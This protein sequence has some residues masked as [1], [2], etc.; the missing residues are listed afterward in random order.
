[1][2]LIQICCLTICS[3][4]TVFLSRCQAQPNAASATESAIRKAAREFNEAF[5]RGDAD[6]VA[7]HFTPN[8]V[9]V[10]DRGQRFEGRDAIRTEYEKLFDNVSGLR[11]VVEIDSI[12]ILNDTTA[13]EEG[14]VALMP[15]PAGANRVMSAYS[16]VHLLQD[17]KWLMAEVRD[18]R[19]VLPPEKGRMEDLDWIIGSWFAQRDDKRVDLTISRIPNSPFLTRSHSITDSG[20]TTSAGVEIMGV[21]PVTG[22]IT[23]W[24]FSSDGGRAVGTWVPD[25]DGWL[26]EST[27]VS[28]DGTKSAARYHVN[29]KDKDSFT[30][31]ST[32]RWM[33]DVA[34]PDMGD[35]TLKRK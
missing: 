21:D 16:A 35:V 33:G 5:D 12:R 9:Y 10:N 28:K 22:Q 17:G 19:I 31:N 3:C 11:L 14:R 24:T 34:L 8:G 15:Q 27:G 2:K 25:G 7:S 18:T 20:E 26:I 29:P 32:N 23:S 13:I 6:L 30:W 4:L 1:M